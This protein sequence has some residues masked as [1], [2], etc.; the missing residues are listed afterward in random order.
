MKLPALPHRPTAPRPGGL[1]ERPTA[2]PGFS[3][4]FLRSFLTLRQW[5]HWRTAQ[6]GQ[7]PQPPTQ[8]LWGDT[9]PSSPFTPALGFGA[10]P[11]A[12]GYLAET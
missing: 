4:L 7:P 6:L 5:Q 11:L 12:R 3:L 8:G 2:A 1:G 10:A 9:H